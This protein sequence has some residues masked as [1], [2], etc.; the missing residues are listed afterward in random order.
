MKKENVKD[1]WLEKQDD[2]QIRRGSEAIDWALLKEY[3]V[4]DNQFRVRPAKS[5]IEEL[6][7]VAFI[8]K[9]GFPALRGC[10]FEDLFHAEGFYNVLGKGD[11]FNKGAN[12]MLVIEHIETGEIAAALIVTLMKKLRRGEHLVISVQK[13]YR[14]NNLGHH[15]LTASDK[16]FED[17]GV[18]MAYGW[19]A[20]YH[21]GTQK[22]LR[23]LGYTARAVIPGLYRLWVTDDEYRRSVEV[24]FQKFFGGAETMCSADLKLIPEINESLVI[25][26]RRE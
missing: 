12:F 16:L 22:I 20:A 19:C 3:T 5:S 2:L 10:E 18:E 26:W 24:F 21:T 14:K 4:E 23:D 6:E 25:P 9:D 17:S 13:K 8:Y 11:S 7:K 1:V 15:I